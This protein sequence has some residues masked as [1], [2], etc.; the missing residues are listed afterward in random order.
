MRH[1]TGIFVHVNLMTF[2]QRHTEFLFDGFP[3]VRKQTT[4]KIIVFDGS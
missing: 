3:W 2:V 4:A 1:G